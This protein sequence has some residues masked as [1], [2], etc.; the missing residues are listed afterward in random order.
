MSKYLSGVGK[1][2]SL[3]LFS[4]AVMS[5]IAACSNLLA[6][7]RTQTPVP[8]L[9]ADQA[10]SFRVPIYTT[11]MNPGEVIP[12]TQLQYFGRENEIFEV[13]I[14]AVRIE[15]RAGDS[16]SWKGIIAPGVIVDFKLRI[17]PTLLGDSMRVAGPAEIWILNPIPVETD[18]GP[19]AGNAQFH[20]TNIAVDLTVAIGDQIPGTTLRYDAFIDGGINLGGSINP[21]R[22]VGDSVVWSGRLRGNVLV[23]YNLRVVSFDADNLRLI[24]TGEIWIT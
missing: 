12:G 20:F 23:N 10:L 8:S 4:L 2:I 7:R 9:P 3:L 18:V 17:S 6:P 1:P 19:L 11:S 24:G 16:F 5:F 15:K 13:S 21:Y 22:A 14:D